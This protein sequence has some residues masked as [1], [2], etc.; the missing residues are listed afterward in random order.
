MQTMAIM[1]ILGGYFLHYNFHNQ[2]Q[3][4]HVY[5]GYLL[6]MS[7]IVIIDQL[8]SRPAGFVTG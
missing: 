5:Y 6:F 2:L 7:W 1:K 8:A 3:F 4:C